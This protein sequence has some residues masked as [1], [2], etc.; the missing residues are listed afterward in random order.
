MHIIFNL[1]YFIF[2]ILLVFA[3]MF[4]GGVSGTAGTFY[5][6]IE[7]GDMQQ[8]LIVAISGLCVLWLIIIMLSSHNKKVIKRN[9]L[10]AKKQ[11]ESI[12]QKN[13]QEKQTHG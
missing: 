10:R 4:L 11:A 6:M 12:V 13:K 1:F 2:F 3:A 8:N 5:L 7:K 9:K